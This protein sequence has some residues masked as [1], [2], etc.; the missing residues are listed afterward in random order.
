[1]KRW[2][3]LSVLA[4]VILRPVS[5]EQE[6]VKPKLID[7]VAIFNRESSHGV[8]NDTNAFVGLLGVFD[9]EGWD[10]GHLAGLEAMLGIE[11]A[12]L[13]GP[14]LRH[15]GLG[16]EANEVNEPN[17]GFE[18]VGELLNHLQ[19][20]PWRI[21]EFPAVELWLREQAESLNTAAEA[22]ARP[23]YFSPLIRSDLSVSMMDAILPHLGP[24]LVLAKSIGI[25]AQ[26]SICLG[27]LDAAINDVAMLRRLTDHLRAEPLMITN[28]VANSIDTI[29]L[30]V[31]KS[32]LSN[33]E[34]DATQSRRLMALLPVD[35]GGLTMSEIF[36]RGERRMSLDFLQRLP[37][38]Q[39][40]MNVLL[41]LDL[42]ALQA[43]TR[44][45]GFSM[46][47]ARSTMDRDYALLVAMAR[48][49]N[50]R[51]RLASFETLAKQYS[52]DPVSEHRAVKVDVTTEEL[53]VNRL[54][55]IVMKSLQT[56]LVV[57]TRGRAFRAVSRVGAALAGYR[58][59]HGWYPKML[60]DLCPHWLAEVPVDLDHKPLR[61][62]KRAGG[63]QLYSVGTDF[64][65]DAGLDDLN[66]GD[67]VLE[68]FKESVI[69][70]QH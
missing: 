18:H 15:Y 44:E 40:P 36:D 56:S 70:I 12:K 38:E 41:S 11:I 29:A 57:E 2:M 25:R 64:E 20:Q 31:V 68:V 16:G 53:L 24:S 54:M 46:K 65:D 37:G 27:D 9:K 35:V 62:Q 32:I 69:E 47:L 51:A 13:P 3:M 61:Y 7:Y 30:H 43:M 60:A 21:E 42:S 26:R 17:Y 33:A 28:L 23:R 5:A 63:Y 1:M 14:T 49:P 19:S 22:I 8:T 67:L 58:A 66:D 39:D 45:E 59:E 48:N 34:L 55:G 50:D 4:C 52:S 6:A 10:P